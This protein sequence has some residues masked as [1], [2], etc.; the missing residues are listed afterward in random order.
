MQLHRYDVVI[1]GVASK[2]SPDPA[3]RFMSEFDMD[4]LNLFDLSGEIRS[5]LDL[6]GFPTTYVFNADGELVSTVMG[7]ITE[8]GL[9]AAIES[10]S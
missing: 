4:Y 2:D 1:V 5:R 7:G 8:R 10:V 6:R 3:R 9:A